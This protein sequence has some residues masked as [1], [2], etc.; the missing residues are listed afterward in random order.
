MSGDAGPRDGAH[1]AYG[2]HAVERILRDGAVGGLTL[3][4]ADAPHGRRLREL[5]RLAASHGLTVQRLS[6]EALDALVGGGRH[7][8][9][10]AE[11]PSAT[12]EP[13]ATSLEQRVAEAG[14]SFLALVLDGVQDPH[15]LGACLRS[16]AG[17]GAHAVI[18]PRDRACPVTATV[19]RVACGA[20][21]L[22]PVYRVTNLVR[23]LEKLQQAG[24]WI[25][26]AAA[27]APQ[28]LYDV[29]LRGPTAL[30]LGGEERGL[31][32]RT[33][34]TCDRMAAIPMSGTME[35][36]NV[37]VAAALFLFEAVRQRREPA[38]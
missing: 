8:G 18:V 32:A 4:V 21:E 27:D 29:D 1:R 22:V 37:S 24:V 28:A 23:D 10:V 31:R 26:G 16:A 15:N 6:T 34:E 5:L 38:S 33:R 2:I 13:E 25:T 14:D 30:V 19:R 9:V 17:A 36:L 7:Q 12:L 11:L 3:H 20:A 35:S